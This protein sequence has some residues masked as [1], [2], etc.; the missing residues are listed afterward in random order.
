MGGARFPGLA[1]PRWGLCRLSPPSLAQ[2]AGG[3][4]RRRPAAR[5]PGGSVAGAALCGGGLVPGRL[6]HAAGRVVVRPRRRGHLVLGRPGR[7]GAQAALG[8]PASR[9]AEQGAQFVGPAPHVQAAA[10]EGREAA[11]VG[12]V[13]ARGDAAVRGAL[14]ADLLQLP[15]PQRPGGWPRGTRCGLPG[16]L[17]GRQPKTLRRRARRGWGRLWPRREPAAGADVRVAGL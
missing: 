9:Q 6:A 5:V 17:G 13:A 7:A 11:R 10:C 8:R 15:W 1:W 14:A 16:G 2:P 3:T 12:G 4:P